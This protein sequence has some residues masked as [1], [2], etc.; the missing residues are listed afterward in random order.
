MNAQLALA[1]RAAGAC[2][3]LLENAERL[4]AL[5]LACHGLTPMLDLHRSA[6]SE[7]RRLCALVQRED[8][9]A[10]ASLLRQVVIAEAEHVLMEQWG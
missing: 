7:A 1:Y 4:V 8:P 5:A 9:T 3:E 2:Y 6:V 10:A